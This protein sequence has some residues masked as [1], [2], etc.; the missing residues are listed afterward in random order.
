MKDYKDLNI[1]VVGAGTMGSTIAQVMAA[2]GIK[3][4]MADLE[5][6]FLDGAKARIA[7]QIEGLVENGLADE[8]YGKNVDENL[9][10]ILNADIPGVAEKFD[11]VFE[12]VPENKDIK[13]STYKMLN[14]NC[15]PDCIFC[16]NTS[17]MPVFDVTADIMPDQSRFLVTHWFNPPHMMKLVEVV[18]GPK[19]SDEVGQYVKGLLEFAGKK[20]AVL[21]HYCPGFIVNR[22]ATVINREFYYMIQQGWITG[23]D[24]ENAMKYTNGI[25]WGF[26]GPTSLWD[27][28]GLDIT[29]AVARDVLPTLCNDAE[30]IKYGE[31]LLAKGELGMKADKGVFDWSDIDKDEWAKMRNRRI[32][33]MTKV[34]DQWTKEDEESGMILKASK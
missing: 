28:V 32:L 13:H 12:V 2:A 25:R 27:F 21:K 33:Q 7:T 31:E 6:R 4:T 19:T 16:S 24:A 34:V 30:T 11:L 9:D 8:S 18:Y 29:V 26:E 14:D 22:I 10:T 5:Q 23:E 3:T 17:G 20:P 15:R 1:L